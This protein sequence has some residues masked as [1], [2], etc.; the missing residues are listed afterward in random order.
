MTKAAENM[1]N[2]AEILKACNAAHQYGQSAGG[3]MAEPFM[4]SVPGM[5]I[6]SGSN[7]SNMIGNVQD[8]GR[9]MLDHMTAIKS[10][11]DKQVAVHQDQQRRQKTYDFQPD[12]SD[13][14]PSDAKG[15]PTEM[16]EAFFAPFMKK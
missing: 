5:N 15:F 3:S 10:A 4:N 1:I 14:R 13:L 2:P 6:A 12:M 8:V 16:P 11:V 9:Q 7:A